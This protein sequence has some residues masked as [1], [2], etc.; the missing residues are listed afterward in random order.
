MR[1][2]PSCSRG[3]SYSR[4]CTTRP[5]ATGRWWQPSLAM[6]APSGYVIRVTDTRVDAVAST[7]VG[8]YRAAQTL[9]QIARAFGDRWPVSRMVD[10]PDFPNRGVM[11]DISRGKVPTMETLYGL[12][13]RFAA[14]KYNQVQLYTEHTFAY[15]QHREVWADASPMTGEEILALDEYCRERYIELVPNQNT[16]GHMRPWLT[17][18]RYR[19]LAE[20]PN[21][22][23]TRW[24]WFD[25]P[26]SLNPGDP[27]GLALVSSLLDELLPHFSSRQVNVGCDETVD[28]GEGRSRNAVAERGI[29]PVFLEFL[30]KVHGEVK[31]RGRTMQFWGDIL[32]EHPELVDRLP[33]ETIAL[34]WG[35]EANHP[36]DEHGAR[37]AASGV[38]FYV[39]PGTS[40]WNSIAGRTHN[41]LANLENAARSGLRHGAI[42]YL[43]TDWG[44]NG[45]WQPLAVSLLPFFYGAGY[46]WCG[47]SARRGGPLDAADL[48]LFGSDSGSIAHHAYALGAVDLLMETPIH[49]MAALFRLLQSS[50]QEIQQHFSA[51]GESATRARLDAVLERLSRL[52]SEAGALHSCASDGH[53]LLKEFEWAA[54]MLA[55]ACRRGQWVV[56]GAGPGDVQRLLAE[57]A[58][59]LM[60]DFGGLWHARYRSGGFDGSVARM[61]TL[62]DSYAS[63]EPA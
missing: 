44:D 9:S 8:L 43:V 20:A 39:C 1:H 53:L 21:G 32:M 7:P 46:A 3:V 60:V 12:V 63:A 16:F 58:S 10:W 31:R 62:A 25:E 55:H 52:R 41:A 36:F 40:S 45:H 13:D 4:R 38:P 50:P 57:D 17:L 24:G 42:G 14:L 35:Y 47:A 33:R 6:K 54:D 48:Y 37:F 59:R 2:T 30:L 26:F 49:N 11:L 56:E 15:R 28:L 5:A 51:E 23:N 19:D 22:C 61:R 18:D 29:G 34:E 27:R